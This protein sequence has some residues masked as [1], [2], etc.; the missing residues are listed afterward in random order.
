MKMSFI[1]DRLITKFIGF[2]LLPEYYI[3]QLVSLGKQDFEELFKHDRISVR[4]HFEKM[5]QIY[6]RK[7]DDRGFQSNRNGSWCPCD[8]TC[9]KCKEAK[10]STK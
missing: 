10:N 8:G 9:P 6:N 2:T 4:E 3:M 7:Y 5:S 1:Y